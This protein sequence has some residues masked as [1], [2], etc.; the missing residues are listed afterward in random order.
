VEVVVVVV[1]QT[2]VV[3]NMFV[4]VV[5]TSFGFASKYRGSASKATMATATNP[6]ASAN[7]V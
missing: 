1:V 2:L 5:I 4:V 7:T 6:T 3:E